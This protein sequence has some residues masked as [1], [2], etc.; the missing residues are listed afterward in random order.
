MVDCSH[1]NSRKDPER[2]PRGRAR[3]RGSRSAPARAPSSGLM[4]ESHLVGGR[5]DRVPGKTLTYG[6]SITDACLA[7]DATVP[8]L[9]EL[10]VAVRARRGRAAR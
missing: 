9:E 2:Q 7:W 6:Q 3:R 5:Q 1:G 10:A 4:I 8:A